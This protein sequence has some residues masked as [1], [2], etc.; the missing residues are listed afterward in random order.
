VSDSAWPQVWRALKV[1]APEATQPLHFS[2]YAAAL[3][4]AC[5][6]HG[7]LLAPLPFSE[8]EFAT[9]RLIR[10]SNICLSGGTGYALLMRRELADSSRGRA[11]RRRI[12][13]EIKPAKRV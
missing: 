11:L 13:A 6:G 3:E 8:R 2:S 1:G 9:G 4:A 10:L 5:A 7:V 12:I